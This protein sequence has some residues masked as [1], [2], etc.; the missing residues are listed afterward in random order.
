[1][2]FVPTA[3][4]HLSTAVLL[5]LVTASFAAFL[6]G[7]YASIFL[8]G[9]GVHQA[10]RYLRSFRQDPRYI[11]FLVIAVI[12][13]ETF[14]FAQ[15]IDIWLSYK[16]DDY[17]V[18]LLVAQ[19]FFIR[20]VA[21]ITRRHRLLV[22]FVILCLV[23]EI[24]ASSASYTM[25]KNVLSSSACWLH[26]LHFRFL[27]SFSL[28]T[29]AFLSAAAI[30]MAAIADTALTIVY[31]ISIR[32]SRK[33]RP[34]PE[35]ESWIDVLQLYLVNTGVATGVFNL[36]AFLAACALPPSQTLVPLSIGSISTRLYANTLL[37][38]L[39][40]RQ[41]RG[42]EFVSDAER[43]FSLAEA[44]VAAKLDLWNAPQLP[45]PVAPRK[46]SIQ[47]HMQNEG[48]RYM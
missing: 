19:T 40:S 34:R 3:E 28:G 33:G 25:L 2:P 38:A 39:N 5:N 1:M 23:A 47:V 16:E 35:S 46:I 27:P 48:S 6:I 9:L 18:G 32:R 36:L 30:G 10:Y 14:H 44:R 41:Q 42:M 29:A 43:K 26:R 21:L 22:T 37:A 8:Y 31:A 13:L 15:T 7:T 12:L 11:T 24:G 45:E 20:R 4:Q 17:A